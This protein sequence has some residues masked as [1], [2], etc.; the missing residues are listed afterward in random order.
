MSKRLHYTKPHLL[1]K[2]HDE[3]IAAGIVPER[4]EGDGEDVWLTVTDGTVESAVAAVVDAHDPTPPPPP[5]TP[6][7]ALEA[8]LGATATLLDVK[9]TLVAWAKEYVD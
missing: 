9:A 3:L 4:V 6:G 1:S 2:L 8:A 5:P 7:E